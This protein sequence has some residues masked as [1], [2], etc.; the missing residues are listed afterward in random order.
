MFF[1]YNKKPYFAK[2]GQFYKCS[3]SANRVFVDFEKPAKIKAK[4]KAFYTIDE[5][6]H[7]LN[8]RLVDGWDAVNKKIIKVSN[9][10][11]SSLNAGQDTVTTEEEPIEA[12]QEENIATDVNVQEE[13]KEA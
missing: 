5:V 7:F 2:D 9:Q 12:P 13:L 3:I 1:I 8:I 6:R 10:T 11:I 4:P